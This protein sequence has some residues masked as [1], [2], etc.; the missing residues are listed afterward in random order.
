MK[1]ERR[2][3]WMKSKHTRPST[4][5]KLALRSLQREKDQKRAAER[6]TKGALS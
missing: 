5:K 4:I 6:K 1:H 3:Y 2:P